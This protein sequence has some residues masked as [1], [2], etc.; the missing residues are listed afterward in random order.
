MASLSISCPCLQSVSLQSTRPAAILQ[1]RLS[2]KRPF[3]RQ[4]CRY[5]WLSG[6]IV[7]AFRC[8]RRAGGGIEARAGGL[9]RGEIGRLR[10]G[11]VDQRQRPVELGPRRLGAAERCQR[12]PQVVL[13]RRVVAERGG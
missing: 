9:E 10:S 1:K 11:R 4:F 13:H 7:A 5:L 6:S 12:R 3:L 8:R 2:A